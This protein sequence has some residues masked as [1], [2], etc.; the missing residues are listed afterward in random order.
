MNSHKDFGA[1]LYSLLNLKRRSSADLMRFLESEGFKS[2][3][4]KA[5]DRSTISKWLSGNNAMPL[6][7]IPSILDWLAVEPIT[8][9]GMYQLRSPNALFELQ[10]FEGLTMKI[11]VIE[12][13]YRIE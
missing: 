3:R 6:Q 7:I 12:I 10:P 1:A 8:R 11:Q 5:F 13:A 2:S 9:W 4:G